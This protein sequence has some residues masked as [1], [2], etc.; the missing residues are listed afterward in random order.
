MNILMYIST[1][2]HCLLK[3]AAVMAERDGPEIHFSL[4]A[5]VHILLTA[6]NLFLEKM[7][8]SF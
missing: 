2:T 5:Q 3:P 7:N 6:F 8:V 4:P 1:L